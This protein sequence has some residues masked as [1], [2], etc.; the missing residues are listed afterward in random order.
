VLYGMG[1]LG[2]LRARFTGKD[3]ELSMQSVRMM[4][5]EAPVDHSKAVRELGWEPRPVEESIREAARFWA[6]MKNAKRSSKATPA[7]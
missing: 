6:A 5:A 2:S 4:R 7:E 1:V 3:A